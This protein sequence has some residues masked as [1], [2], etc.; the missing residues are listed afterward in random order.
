MNL[1]LT[2]C[3]VAYKEDAVYKMILSLS[4]LVNFELLNKKIKIN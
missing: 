3:Q 1:S 2:K 4:C